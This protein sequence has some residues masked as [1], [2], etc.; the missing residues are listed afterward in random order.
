MKY[1]ILLGLATAAIVL[2]VVGS[3]S[4]RH[5][6]RRWSLIGAVVLLTLTIA[7]GWFFSHR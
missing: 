7:A 4:S 6:V 3:Q 1:A 2:V 5:R